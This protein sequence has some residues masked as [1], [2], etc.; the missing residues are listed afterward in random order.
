MAYEEKDKINFI[1]SLYCQARLISE[2]T[3]A[4]WELMLAQAAQEVG[5]GEKILPG[6]NNVFNIKADSSWK[7]QSGIFNVWEKVKGKKVWVDAPFRIYASAAE[8]LTDRCKF[9]KENPR[10]T[11]HGLYDPGVQGNFAREA[12]AMKDAGYATDEDYVEAMSKVF[13]GRTMRRA[14]KAAQLDGC[15]PLLPVIEVIVLDGAKVAIRDAKVKL[16]QNGKT[17]DTATNAAGIFNIRITPNSGNI[18]LKIFDDCQNL[19]IDLDPI[20]IPTP[21]KSTTVTLIAPTFVIHTSTREHVKAPKKAAPAAV[22]PAA[23][24]PAAPVNSSS[25]AKG[26]R[27]HTIHK[28]ESLALIAKM[29]S[30]SYKSIAELNN[31]RSP[32]VIRPDQVL[33]IPPAAGATPVAHGGTP[34][35]APAPAQAPSSSHASAPSA[36]HAPARSPAHASTPVPAHAPTSAPAPTTPSRAAAPEVHTIYSRNGASNPQTDVMHASRAPWMTFAESEFKKGV[37]R[38]AGRAHNDA[39]ILAYFTATPSLPKRYAEVDETPYCAAFANWCLTKAG[40]R[41]NNSAGARDFLRW[42]RSTEGNKPALG[43]VAVIRFDTGGYHV[44]FV[45]GTSSR[46]TRIATLGGNQ[47]SAH[48]VSHSSIDKDSIIAYRYPENYPD[49]PDDYVLHDVRS[50]HAPMTA[51]STH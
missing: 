7:G 27:S 12:Q 42:G 40:F 31:I 36:P 19:W 45:A 30:V 15:G 50:D 29:Y 8:S 32:Y 35:A 28:G 47:G 9:L 22:K 51:S 49:N 46:G 10:Y 13:R 41:G 1:K 17:A 20:V 6:T 5:W 25:E 21:A 43:A 24:K 18:A 23:S 48:E 37:K 39:R 38:Q 33:K 3:G 34:A 11:K 44:T 16:T 4:S 14:I 2:Q 26:L